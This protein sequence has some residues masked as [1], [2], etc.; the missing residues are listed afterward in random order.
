MTRFL[1]RIAAAAFMLFGV[2]L[3]Y[4]QTPLTQ[5]QAEL[6]GSWLAKLDDQDTNRT[7]KILNVL[8]KSE[9]TFSLEA[10]FGYSGKNLAEAKAEIS[11]TTAERKLVL[12]T[13][14]GARIVAIQTPDGSFVGKFE[15]NDGIARG[16][17]L[18]KLSE[19]E[20]QAK[21]EAALKGPVIEKPAADVPAQCA[22]FSGKWVGTWTL[23]SQD[24][25]WVVAVDANCQAKFA[26]G[27]TSKFA[28]ASI[29]N[30]TLSF[31]APLCARDGTC[32]FELHG[33]E[34]WAKYSNPAGGWGNA[35]FGKVQ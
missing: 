30:G 20:L 11:Q 15:G 16:V 33:N 8:Q 2:A 14:S 28:S 25:L 34:L 3:A 4:A 21:V 18:T 17:V 22:S 29:T 1:V 24:T 26:Y 27:S 13:R 23:G 6:V 9:G 32:S 5:L 35:V 31:G 10:N 19:N 12:N 7:L